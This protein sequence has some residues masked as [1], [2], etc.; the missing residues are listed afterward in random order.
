MRYPEQHPVRGVLL[1]AG[2]SSRFGSDKLLHK[3]PDGTPVAVASARN[4]AR[5]L[6]RPLAVIRPA[7]PALRAALEAEGCEVIECADAHTGMGAS[8]ACAVRASMEVSGWLV[9]LADM[10]FI[11]PETIAEL[12]KWVPNGAAVAAPIYR[13]QRGHPVCFSNYQRDELLALH[14]DEGARK[15]FQRHGGLGNLVR[16]DDPGVLR[17]IDVPGDVPG[18]S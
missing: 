15:I 9:A 12:A 4:L 6:P 1:A 14:G 3:L 7:S 2:S 5:A 18:G 8:L 10:P 13:G 17:D 16:V 11:R